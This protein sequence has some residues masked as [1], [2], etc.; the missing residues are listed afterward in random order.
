MENV[1]CRFPVEPGA[2]TLEEILEQL[3]G[4]LQPDP[5]EATG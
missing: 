3:L 2:G 1:T 5:P 4:N